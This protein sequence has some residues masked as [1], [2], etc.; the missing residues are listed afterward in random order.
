MPRLLKA[1]IAFLICELCVYSEFFLLEGAFSV[2]NDCFEVLL[3]SQSFSILFLV[4]LEEFLDVLLLAALDD[5]SGR[6]PETPVWL[7]CY[8]ARLLARVK[9]VLIILSKWYQNKVFC[10]EIRINHLLN[11]TTTQLKI[12][13]TFKTTEISIHRMNLSVDKNMQLF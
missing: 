7:V 1:E 3:F 5:G 9:M 10:S 11:S 12:Y 2:C 6:V 4:G 13:W 8:L